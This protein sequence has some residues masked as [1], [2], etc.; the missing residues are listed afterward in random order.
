MADALG[1]GYDEAERLA[2]LAKLSCAL[3]RA[4]P[5]RSP[6]SPPRDTE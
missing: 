4:E 5:C 1:I 3:A 6:L 2:I